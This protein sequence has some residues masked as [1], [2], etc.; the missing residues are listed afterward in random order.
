M[1][2]IFSQYKNIFGQP[3]NGVHSYRLF[4]LPIIDY[5]MSIILAL[6]ITYITKI[7]FELIIII[8]LLMG[9]ISHYLF[10]VETNLMKYF[11]H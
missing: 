11:L 4:N 1:N 6:L 7:P 5:I 9:V 3:Y 10:C 8:V 2:C